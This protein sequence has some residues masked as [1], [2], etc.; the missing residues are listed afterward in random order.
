LLGVSLGTELGIPDG[1]ELGS[2][3]GFELGLSDGT[4]LG[5]ALGPELGP[6]E[7]EPRGAKLGTPLGEAL[8]EPAGDPLG[9]LGEE[10]G[11]P[12]ERAEGAALGETPVPVVR[13]IIT[14]VIMTD[15]L[16]DRMVRLPRRIITMIMTNDLICLLDLT[17]DL[18][19]GLT[20]RLLDL[21]VDR[22]RV[23]V[24]DL[25]LLKRSPMD[26]RS[27]WLILLLNLWMTPQLFTRM[28]IWPKYSSTLK[29]REI[30]PSPGLRMI[31]RNRRIEE[32][33]Y[34]YISSI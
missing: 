5:S 32:G 30:R 23:L 31:C 10:D 6:W 22:L 15:L 27:P 29:G 13:H 4:E 8:G 21:M 11:A 18:A 26:S 17:V 28:R 24:V 3:L 9:E 33:S 12:F 2:E 19:M 25:P 1:D 34:C 14:M 16:P 7:G 20:R